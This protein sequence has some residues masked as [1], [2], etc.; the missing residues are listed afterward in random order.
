MMLVT[1]VTL[2]HIWT[3][4]RAR[5]PRLRLTVQ[6]GLTVTTVTAAP[7][8]VHRLPVVAPVEVGAMTIV[9]LVTLAHIWTVSRAHDAR[10]RDGANR[11]DCHN[12]HG[13]PGGLGCCARAEGVGAVQTLAVAAKGYPF[14]AIRGF[15]CLGELFSKW[16]GAMGKEPRRQ[17]PGRGG[18]KSGPFF[19]RPPA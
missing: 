12:C 4:S 6:T 8:D 9:T 5:A 18:R 19:H 11:V 17:S 13:R 7:A 16:H 2:A 15:S 10:T 14:E 1:I 3:V